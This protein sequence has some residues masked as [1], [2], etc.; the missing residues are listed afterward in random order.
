MFV[1]AKVRIIDEQGIEE[2]KDKTIKRWN[3]RT[4]NDWQLIMG[5]R[6]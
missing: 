2:N 1:F 3:D 5:Q 4:I 6:A